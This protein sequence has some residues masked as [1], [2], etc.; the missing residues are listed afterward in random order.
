M[1]VYKGLLNEKTRLVAVGHVANS[2][3]TVNPIKVITDLAYAQGVPVLVDGAQAVPHMAV[4]VRELDCDFYCFSAH[5][6]FG[7]TGIGVLYGKEDLLESMPPYQSGG[8]MIE[9]VS[10]EKTTFNV[11]PYK[12]AGWNSF[13]CRSHRAGLG[14]RLSDRAWL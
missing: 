10:F 4:D 3:G 14:H 5:K 2:L 13:N 1:D 9:S 6:M 12:F 8:D 11:L 7:P